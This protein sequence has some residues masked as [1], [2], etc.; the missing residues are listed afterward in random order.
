M[1]R[2]KDV[3]AKEKKQKMILAGLGAVLLVVL[4]IELPGMLSGG[5][6]PVRHS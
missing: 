1:A 2:A 6:S 4:A 5:G 3:K